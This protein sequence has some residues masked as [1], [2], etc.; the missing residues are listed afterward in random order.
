MDF[1]SLYQRY[2]R[3]LQGFF[4]R[5]LGGD[6][7]AAADATHDTFLRAFEAR[8]RF[9]NDGNEAAWLFTI[10][11]N[12]LRNRYRRQANEAEFL[13]TLDREPTETATIEVSLDQ[14]TLREAL[15]TVLDGLPPPLRLLFSLHYEEELTVPQVSE[16]MQIP[17]GTVKSRLHK[18]MTIIRKQLK[19]YEDK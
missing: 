15:K 7:Q 19:E 3:R 2:A 1:E 14:K 6:R 13:R 12:L 8:D 16:I 18:T 4:F 10:A 5:Q 9:R 17:E 11:Y